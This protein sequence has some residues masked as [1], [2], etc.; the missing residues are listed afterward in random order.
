[1]CVIDWEGRGME[2]GALL[3]GRSTSW[4]VWATPCKLYRDSRPPGGVM[5]PEPMEYETGMS[6][7]H[8]RNV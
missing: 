1:M 6:A 2:Q 4:K 5:N 3:Q 7:D 8:N